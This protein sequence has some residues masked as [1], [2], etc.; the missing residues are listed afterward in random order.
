MNEPWLCTRCNKMNAPWNAQCFCF[1]DSDL[2]SSEKDLLEK[3][4]KPLITFD[5]IQKAMDKHARDLGYADH[6]EFLIKSGWSNRFAPQHQEDIKNSRCL[7]CNEYHGDGQCAI[8]SE[9]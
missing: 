3:I 8:R 9:K 5:E 2:N 1:P 6:N 7:I 4:K